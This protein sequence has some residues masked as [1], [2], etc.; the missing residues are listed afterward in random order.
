ML[1]VFTITSCSSDDDDKPTTNDVYGTWVTVSVLSKD[2]KEWID[3]T[4]SRYSSLRAYAQFFSNGRY[5]GWGALGNGS[6][7]W[8]LAGKNLITYLNTGEEYIR[9][10]VASLSGDIMTGTMSDGKTTLTFKAQR[11]NKESE[12]Y[13][14]AG[15]WLLTTKYSDPSASYQTHYGII[16]KQ[17][18][19]FSD[20]GKVTVTGDAEIE[21]NG[22]FFQRYKSPFSSYAGYTYTPTSITYDG[23]VSFSPGNKKYGVEFISS[24]EVHLWEDDLYT[25]TY[26]MLKKD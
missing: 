9:Y 26:F 16:G 13:T 17:Y 7:T 1:A 3:L 14:L 21:P 12:Y 23:I 15:R 8:K 6:G 4:D 2:G 5:K 10:N 25:R 11:L 19:A 24:T 18:I 20:D 22:N